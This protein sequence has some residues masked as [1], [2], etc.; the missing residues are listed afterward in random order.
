MSDIE[1]PKSR[2]DGWEAGQEFEMKFFVSD[3]KVRQFA[4]VSGDHNP[5]HLD[6]EFA[7]A[8]IF[9]QRIAHGML[10]A[11][12]LSAFLAQKMPGPG[13]IYRRQELKFLKPVYVNETI[14]IRGILK[15][16]N[17]ERGVFTITTLVIKENGDVAVEGE[18][19]ALLR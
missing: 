13:A 1:K 15:N 6:D 11:A 2:L 7:K 19:I 3:E 4:E 17:R 18:A 10:S 14:T 5:V 8:S 9:G 12:F 16:L